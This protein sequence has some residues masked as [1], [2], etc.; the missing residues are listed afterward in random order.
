MTSSS[1]LTSTIHQVI[2]AT[3]AADSLSLTAHWEYNTD[4]ITKAYPSKVDHLGPPL[5]SY[6]SGKAAGDQTHIGD[7]ALLLL[8]HL[9][10]NPQHILDI[11]SYLTAWQAMWDVP[12][13]PGYVDHA[14]KTLLQ[15]IKDG[16]H[17]AEAAST[18]DDL[19]HSSKFFPLLA[20][21]V[22][23]KDEEALVKATRELVSTFQR[24]KEEQISGEFLARVAYRVIVR[25]ERPTAAID[26]VTS[27][28]NDPWLSD[29][30]KVGKASASQSD[31]EAL[32]S[33]GEKK[34]LSGGKVFYSGYSCGVKYGIPT[35]VH[36]VH[37]YEDA[38][39]PTQA[40]IEDVSVGGNSN[41][42]VM[43]LAVLL[44]GYRGVKGFKVEQLIAGIKQKDK[45]EEALKT[46]EKG[47]A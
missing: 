23:Q 41:A 26:A 45:I 13:P 36:Y 21:P 24:G 2:L 6:H 38:S 4:N 44:F 11:P 39:D 29:R 22:Y 40:L 33:F 12:T 7:N 19:S 28:L 20:S 17:G 5:S 14:T 47:Q 15:S 1:S 31:V 32:R 43:A 34:E 9:A 42:R 46:I 3:F 10:H 27:Q 8:N 30:V 35:V 18:D 25:K 37:K 16:K